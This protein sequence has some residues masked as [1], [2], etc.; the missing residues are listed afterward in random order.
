MMHC[1][2]CG[3]EHGAAAKFCPACGKATR[4]SADPLVGS[5]LGERYQLIE[6]IGEG[7]SGTIYRAL[8]I[9]LRRP[10][11]I[12]VLHHALAQN[13]LAVE[14]FRREAT[15]VGQIDN[16]HIVQIHDFDR[17]ADG[18]LYLAMEL[19]DGET[20]AARLQR[21]GRLEP[22]AAVDIL[23]QLG[24]ALSE[25]HSMGYI[26]RDLRPGNVFLARRRGRSDFVKLL[27][28]GLSKLVEERRG[29]AA[30]TSLGM[31]FGDPRYMSPEQARGDLVD[32]RADI[33]SLGCIAYE[34]LVGTPPFAGDR[35]FDILT[36][37]VQQ[38]PPRPAAQRAGVP[39]WLDGVI[40]RML[41]KRAEER[42]VTVYRLV[43]ALQEGRATGTIMELERA[44]RSETSPPVIGEPGPAGSAGRPPFATDMVETRP[45]S[46]GGHQAAHGDTGASRTHIGHAPRPA[47]ARGAR[48]GHPGDAPRELAPRSGHLDER[49]DVAIDEFA[50]GHAPPPGAEPAA[51]PHGLEG[52]ASAGHD[53]AGP[54]HRGR[55][56]FVLLRASGAAHAPAHTEAPLHDADPGPGDPRHLAGARLDQRGAPDDDDIPGFAAQPARDPAPPRAAPPGQPPRDASLSAAWFADGEEVPLNTLE[57]RRLDA[58]R[59]GFLERSGES[60]GSLGELYVESRWRSRRLLVGAAIAG[61]GLGVAAFLSWPGDQQPAALEAN[62]TPAATSP[63]APGPEPAVPT[64]AQALAVPGLDTAPTAG[65]P[66]PAHREPAAVADPAPTSGPEVEPVVR[67]A[68][69]GPSAA[70]PEAEPT[71]RPELGSRRRP[72]PGEGSTGQ[73]ASTTPPPA[74]TQPAPSAPEPEPTPPPRTGPDAPEPATATAPAAAPGVSAQTESLTAQGN[75]ALQDGDILGAAGSFRKALE[76]DGK[77][78]GALVGLGEVALTQGSYRD[79]VAHLR[80][81]SKL[82]AAGARVHVLLGEAYLGNRQ[83]ALAARS[84]R[85]ALQLSPDDERARTGYLEATK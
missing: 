8:H 65:I 75:R 40:A 37:H 24:D 33:Y 77:H 52:D 30:S 11:A 10:V 22:D 17:T 66:L 85:R 14:R 82:G 35:V 49:G 45:Y 27:D 79:A 57:M 73:A 43:Q 5:C 55:G 6:R 56:D 69:R 70:R 23:L 13:E 47:A 61:L 53:A 46:P 38:Q 29:A 9:T 3:L 42:F 34:M 4:G 2:W 60:T 80:R 41:A 50:R 54:L 25:A 44:T 74:D 67:S 64:P 62:R 59:A 16:E 58:A 31:T 15:T 7:T 48:P 84:F 21:E 19:L 76:L 39:P 71:T 81:A 83:P 28:F 20:L 68:R 26:H 1:A 36:A 63:V 78:A 32:R 18:R 72:R 51:L 12:K